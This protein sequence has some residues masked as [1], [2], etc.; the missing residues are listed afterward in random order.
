MYFFVIDRGPRRVLIHQTTPMHVV[1]RNG[2]VMNRL[3]T[4]ERLFPGRRPSLQ[5]PHQSTGA[6]LPIRSLASGDAVP[7][8]VG[9]HL[10]QDPS[11][12]SETR[13]QRGCVTPYE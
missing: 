11:E 4:P 5:V 10:A 6:L 2:P 13:I 3:P 12:I 8:N 1:G 7:Q 9:S